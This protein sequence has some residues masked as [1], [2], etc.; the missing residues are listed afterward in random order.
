MRITKKDIY[1]QRNVEFIPKNGGYIVTPIG[2]IKPLLKDGNEKTGKRCKTFSMQAGTKGTCVCD[3]GGCYAQTGCFNY[4]CV[5]ESM[6]INQTL[7]ENHLSFVKN[8]ILAQIEAD[9]IEM[10]RIHASGDFNTANSADYANM[11]HE[12]VKACPNV[13]FWTYT[14]M[15]QYE[16]LFDDCP[17][18][19]IVPS[20]LPFNLGFNFGTCAELL[21]MYET[22]KKHGITPHVC[23][24][25]VNDD[26]HCENC[27]GCSVNRYVL[28][29]KHSV[30]DYDAKKDSLLSDVAAIIDAQKT[31]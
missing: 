15:K 11:W 9:K 20:V 18:A 13:K 22:M 12:I 23:E 3:C 1:A 29:V 28:F 17:N 27:A 30:E 26:H 14:K 5:K 24:C 8:A 19:N 10:V 25:G 16:S 7:V 2:I 21:K 31:A 4:P 6:R